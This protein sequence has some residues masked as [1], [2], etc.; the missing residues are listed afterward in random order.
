MGNYNGARFEPKKV[1]SLSYY[2]QCPSKDRTCMHT[3]VP[4]IAQNQINQTGDLKV[5]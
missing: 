3:I 5:I 4:S 2:C 1:E